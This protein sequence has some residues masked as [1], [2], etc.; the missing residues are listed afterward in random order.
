[1]PFKAIWKPRFVDLALVLFECRYMGV[2]K[3]GKTIRPKRDALMNGIDARC[4]GLLRQSV[5]QVEI[6]AVDTRPPQGCR[7]GGGLIEALQAVDSAL[8]QRIEALNP[9]TR[10]IDPT[11]RKRID[12]R[13][14]QRT[15]IDLDG[16]F[17]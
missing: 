14:G 13:C 9:E 1:M 17:S 7:G 12:H 4:D 8:H 5:D 15:R 11:I 16:D 10:T 2:T 6:D 3:N